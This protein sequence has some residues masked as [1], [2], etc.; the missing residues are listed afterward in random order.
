[1]RRKLLFIVLC[2]LFF[3]N[4][5]AINK[6]KVNLYV[7]KDN[8]VS[9][10]E[11]INI[12]EDF[13]LKLPDSGNI[14]NEIYGYSLLLKK[15]NSNYDYVRK[16]N[17][18]SFSTKG[19]VFVNT[20]YTINYKKSNTNSYYVLLEGINKK[21]D[22]VEIV[23]DF[24]DKTRIENIDFYINNE[25]NDKITY[26]YDEG[27]I[28][29]SYYYLDSNSVIGVKVN[30]KIRSGN[31]TVSLFSLLFPIFSLIV[32]ILIW[33]LFGRD[34]I[35][36]KERCIYP[37]KRLNYFDVV[38]LYKE[39]VDK[40]DIIA[41]LFML[42]S[43][44]YVSIKEEKDDIKLIYNKKYE[45]HSYSESILFDSLFLK[46]YEG[47]LSGV[48]DKNRKKKYVDVISVKDIRIK[49]CIDLIKA[50]EN[51]D[52]KRYEFFEKGTD[53]K[54][55][56]ILG[57]SIISM[58]VI[59]INPFL[60]NMIYMLLGMIIS[61][62]LY[63]IM[64]TIINS[65][66]F[67]KDRKY[68]FT[69]GI[70][71]MFLVIILGFIIGLGSIYE[72][73][74]FIGVICII[75]MLLLAKYMPKRTIYGSKLYSKLEGFK[76]LLDN[77]NSKDYNSILDYNE[78]YYYDILSYTYLFNNREETIKKFNKVIKKECDWYEGINEYSFVKFNKLCDVI[79]DILRENN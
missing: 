20:E 11:T 16:N 12:Y 56:I 19:N 65:M 54:K 61:S 58:L 43:N 17:I 14:P 75:V 62:L 6:Y 28:V 41:N 73:S 50:N 45:G 67:N 29:A 60:G 51:V 39:K 40:D 49:R 33:Y 72:L 47:S 2:I 48:I 25:K 44:G 36:K 22:L 52:S 69:I 46:N 68:L 24:E 1:M 10:K 78:D 57:L 59:I 53:N 27:K 34:K 26:Y 77:G 38:R 31:S 64:Y 70:V 55:K 5:Y 79:V 23:I 32:S 18:I 63:T 30:K 9:K 37:D 66:N 35:L 4:V 15:V 71:L 8:N 21:I 74:L 42:C 13:E 76:D 3:P 7:D